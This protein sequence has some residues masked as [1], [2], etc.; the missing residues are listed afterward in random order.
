MTSFFQQRHGRQ[1]DQ[2]S[3]FLNPR[4]YRP[5]SDVKFLS[6]RRSPA[7]GCGGREVI[8][9]TPEQRAGWSSTPYCLKFELV[10]PGLRG[11]LQDSGYFPN[12]VNC[13]TFGDLCCGPPPTIN[14]VMRGCSAST[15]AFGLGSDGP[16]PPPTTQLFLRITN[17]SGSH[18]MV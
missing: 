1:P 12:A 9:L 14:P 7:R 15:L 17:H 5:G 8:I 10:S 18:R 11:S 4:R 13:K 3:P 6:C 2:G 16:S